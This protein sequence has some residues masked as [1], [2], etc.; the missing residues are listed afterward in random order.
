MRVPSVTVR[1][2]VVTA[3][4]LVLV[5]LVVVVVVALRRG[6]DVNDAATVWCLAD[7][8]RPELVAAARDLTVV[9]PASTVDKVGWPGGSGDLAGWRAARG[10]DF[11][12]TCRALIGAQQ[13]GK[14]G[15]DQSPWS[16]FAPSLAL[17]VASAV[18]AAW[19]SRRLAT[20][21]VRRTEADGLRTAVR[22]YRVAAERLLR[23]LEQPRPG[24]APTDGE[25]Q[26]RRLELAT[27]LN[28]VAAG[29]RRWALPRRLSER[30][31]EDPFGT[32]LATVWGALSP[33]GRPAWIARTRVALGRLEAEV[34]EVAR[35]VQEPGLFRGWATD[36]PGGGVGGG[37]RQ[38]VEPGGS[39]PTEGGPVGGGPVGAR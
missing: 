2:G 34:E 26:D 39:G 36:G 20:A 3:A 31:D 27:R 33:A 30:L 16:T 12:R 35:M 18:L 7:T 10:A 9:T 13:Q 28:G 24:I 1:R 17:A 32:P 22:A 6:G 4:V 23:D 14:A 5:G 25:A 11:A 8:R 15:G 38:P 37:R 19:F 29:R 21:G